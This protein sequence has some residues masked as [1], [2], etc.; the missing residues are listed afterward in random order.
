M[1]PGQ[2]LERFAAD[3][4]EASFTALVTLHGPMVLGVCRRALP[5]RD[6]V[7]DAF[8]ATFLVLAR[9][10]GS[11]RQPDLLGP[12]LHGVARRVA[13]R[14][15]SRA[16]RRRAV[17]RPGAELMA[18]TR[19]DDRHELG[20]ALDEE[21]ARLPDRYRRPLVLCYLEGRTREEAARD[22]RWT[23]GTVRGRLAKAREILRS[24]LARRGLAPSGECLVGLSP[25]AAAP[26]VP[27]PLASATVGAA[28]LFAAG[29]AAS[30]GPGSATASAIAQGVLRAMIVTPMRI[31]ATALLASGLVALPYLFAPGPT[32]NPQA[33]GAQAP[34]AAV[35]P[36]E[37]LMA[38][39]VKTYAEARSYQDEG[40]VVLVFIDPAG[41]RTQ[42]KPFTTRF[43]RPRLFRF[44]FTER[45]SFEELK[46]YVIWSDAA[47]DR[48]KAW[49]TVRPKVE[50]QS[51]AMCVGAAAGVSSLS[52]LTVPRLLMPAAIPAQSLAD[53]RGPKIEDV[54]VVDGAPCDRVEGTDPRGNKET[55]WIDKASS[56]VRKVSLTF[57]I[58]GGS[59]ESTTTYRPQI[60]VEIAAD[61]FAFEPPAGAK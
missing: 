1:T 9:K 44:E 31:T 24:R 19:D 41:R 43:V 22:L 3:R 11:I 34:A 39:M 51:L 56:L 28:I 35:T 20:A 8:Q 6:D 15:R 33:P 10:A 23:T 17:E 52:S 60:G 58:P 42:K 57:K 26:V 46:R 7:D 30:V 16:A 5:D 25:F 4:D 53:L 36:A 59:V 40:E 45:D 49:W 29:R 27:P 47:P 32:P 12:W 55:L 48:A 18:M 50:E 38:R 37:Q 13:T 21:I 2:L 61:A 14:M 54:E